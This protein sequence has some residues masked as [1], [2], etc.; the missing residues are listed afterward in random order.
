MR[1]K[2]G[3]SIFYFACKTKHTWSMCMIIKL[4]TK[5]KEEKHEGETQ[6]VQFDRML[7]ETETFAIQLT[8]TWR[9]FRRIDWA[10]IF[11]RSPSLSLSTPLSVDL[12]TFVSLQFCSF[13]FRFAA[14]Q[15]K[16]P[17]RM[18]NE[19]N[20]ARTQ[21]ENAKDKESAEN[22]QGNVCI[23]KVGKINQV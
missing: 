18:K 19:K 21:R 16:Y 14:T 12:N 8:V 2:K 10:L 3:E 17:K 9:R 1:R 6:L 7:F 15:S 4:P 23:L 11:F 20:T 13:H 22:A 5:S